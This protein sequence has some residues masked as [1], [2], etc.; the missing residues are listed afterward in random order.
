MKKIKK[1]SIVVLIL[2]ILIGFIQYNH[3]ME[4][5]REIGKLYYEKI[6]YAY[7]GLNKIKFYLDGGE[8]TEEGL[9]YNGKSINDLSVTSI[10]SGRTAVYFQ[11]V[12]GYFMV[13]GT[14]T[15]KDRGSEEFKECIEEAKYFVNVLCDE[16]YKL[17]QIGERENKSGTLY[18]DYYKYYEL[19][20]DKN[21]IVETF[22][23]NLRAK[24]EDI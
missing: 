1:H 6:N 7:S 13:A 4:L 20:L 19:S 12:T 10:E 17:Q 5:K 21:E 3:S 9:L 23:G 16:F 24:L 2:V 22:I 8:F 15:E 18:T 14:L 11:R